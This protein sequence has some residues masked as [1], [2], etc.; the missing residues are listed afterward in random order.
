VSD[1]KG[2]IAQHYGQIAESVIAGLEVGDNSAGP[3]IVFQ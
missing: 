3:E 2:A 1:P